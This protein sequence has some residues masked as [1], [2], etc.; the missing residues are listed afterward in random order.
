MTMISMRHANLMNEDSYQS[1]GS[2]SSSHNRANSILNNQK[3]ADSAHTMAKRISQVHQNP[4]GQHKRYVKI[5]SVR[6]R[7]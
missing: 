4:H 7:P 2:V 1:R 6:L 5:V 3:V